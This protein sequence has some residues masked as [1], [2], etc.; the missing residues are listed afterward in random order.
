MVVPQCRYFLLLARTFYRNRPDLLFALFILQE[1][2]WWEHRLLL[3]VLLSVSSPRSGG[4]EG[5]SPDSTAASRLHVVPGGVFLAELR[6]VLVL[7]R[8]N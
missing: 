7:L 6:Y 5:F 3:S 2:E 4:R 8:Y 1:S